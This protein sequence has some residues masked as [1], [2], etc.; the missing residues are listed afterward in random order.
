M[1]L[2]NNEKLMSFSS[3]SQSSTYGNHTA[4]YGHNNKINNND[5]AHTGHDNRPWW[6]GTLKNKVKISKVKIYNRISNKEVSDRIKGFTLEIHNDNTIL[7]RYTDNA[8]NSKPI[9]DIEIPL[10]K[11]N[12]V[13]IQLPGKKYLNFREIQAFCVQDVNF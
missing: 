4:G 10:V 12:K 2:R 5:M 7:Y 6:K 8:A 1:V 3:A 11:G 13:K 9:Y